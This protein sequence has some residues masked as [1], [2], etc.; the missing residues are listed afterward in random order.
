VCSISTACG[1]APAPVSPAPV[2][3]PPPTL[4]GVV[5]Y[6]DGTPAPGATLA[7][8]DLATA[9][10][11]IAIATDPDGHFQLALPS[12]D[13]A[14]AVTAERGFAWLD[15]QA[16]PDPSVR[17]ALSRSCHPLTGRVSSHGPSTLVKAA[18][19][20]SATGDTFVSPVQ[21]DGSFAA[22]L[23]EAYY[24]VSLA[25][26]TMSTPVDLQVPE[27]T[28]VELDGVAGDI[29]RRPPP[30]TAPI[31][32]ELAGLVADIT[33][34]DPTIIGLGEGTHGTA[35]FVSARAELTLA[36]VRSAGVRLILFELDAISGVALDDYVNGG[37]VDL[38]GAVAALGF[39]VTDTYEFLRFL[40]LVRDY[41]ANTAD[42]I[43]LWGV[44]LQNTALPVG[45]LT[46]SA[47]ALSIGADEQAALGVVAT[48][49]G[50]EVPNLP[51]AQR[52]SL[53][54]LLSRLA[55]PRSRARQDL[56]VAVAA[57]SLALQ[58]EYWNGDMRGQ[59]RRRRDA[60]MATLASFITSQLGVQRSCLWAHDGHLTK[61]RGLRMVGQNLAANPAVRYYGVGF[62]LY[63][64]SARAWDAAAKIGV[65]PHPIPAAPAYTLEGAVMRAAGMPD[66]AWI[67]LAG[68]PAP[69]LD[70]LA[71][72]RLVRELGAAYT[73]ADDTLTLRRVREAFD[74]VVVIKHGHDSSPTPTGVR[75]VTHD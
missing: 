42:K 58:L 5:S 56:L 17:I 65:I 61:E 22:C 30:S 24:N 71:T 47:A 41:N 38:A 2:P 75:K 37:D 9:G 51:A 33:A 69:L 14:L 59:Y 44:D 45:V 10:R 39:W 55:T 1:A 35:E 18:R 53:S 72:P 67:P 52:A 68:L 20:S 64:G 32:A 50:K 15:K 28:H 34:R 7:V 62:Y 36:L 31:P 60:G 74:A 3:S 46:A 49:R 48:S 13:Y 21:A 11:V 6:D 63:E 19:R 40:E 29:V 8:T 16:V 4:R 12:G 54:S 57:R 23:P 70:W 27:T 26:E 73:V 43:H 25:G 66:I